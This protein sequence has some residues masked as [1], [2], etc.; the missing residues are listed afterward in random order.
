MENL[1][2]NGDWIQLAQD[3]KAVVSCENG[4]KLS[5]SSIS[6]EFLG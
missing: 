2:D 5:V 6:E 4:N 1:R 3:R